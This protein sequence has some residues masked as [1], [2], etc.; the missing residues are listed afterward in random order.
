MKFFSFVFMLMCLPQL[1]HAQTFAPR[2]GETGQVSSSTIDKAKTVR[3][4]AN[5]NVSKTPNKSDKAS[6]VQKNFATTNRKEEAKKYDNTERKAF[7]FKIVKGKVVFDEERSILIWYSNYK[8]SRSFGSY[9][10]CSL[11]I[12]VLN[13]L[14][15]PI[16][17]LAFQLHWKNEA[18]LKMDAAFEM[19]KL[20]PGVNTYKDV[21]LLGDG[22]SIMDGTPMI[23][24]NRC[25]AK[26]LSQDRC[27]DAVKWFQNR[28]GEQ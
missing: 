8:T 9:M 14:T 4:T 23:E 12:H 20:Q 19:N 1:L 3:K 25:R 16:N 26:G 10:Q 2:A 6:Y 13:D 18:G 24:V 11:R 17:S 28:R 7:S 27:A 5:K 21:V 15:V 22:C